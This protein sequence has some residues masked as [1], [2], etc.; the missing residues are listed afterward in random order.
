M[1]VRLGLAD[2]HKL[3]AGYYYIVDLYK[4]KTQTADYKLYR[5]IQTQI[6]TT[7]QQ[8]NIISVQE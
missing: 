1:A 8:M 2:W 6:K 5:K 3:T 7:P 4:N